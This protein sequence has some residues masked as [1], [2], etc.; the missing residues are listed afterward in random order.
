MN[1]TQQTIKEFNDARDWSD[2]KCIKDILLN[3][4]EEIG[5]F[6]NVKNV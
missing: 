4:N 2:P 6:W 1:E 3:M 5:E